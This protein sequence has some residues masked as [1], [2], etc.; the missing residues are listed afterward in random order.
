MIEFVE[1]PV[2]GQIDVGRMLNLVRHRVLLREP[3]PVVELVTTLLPLH[4]PM[5]QTAVQQPAQHVAMPDA[6]VHLPRRL[7]RPGRRHLLSLSEGVSTDDRLVRGRRGVNPLVLRIP[8]QLGVVP[9]SH[10]LDIDQ[11][12][13]LALLVPHLMTG[14]P[15]IPQ[16]RPDSAFRPGDSTAMPVPRPIVRARRSDAITREPLRD[17]VDSDTTEVLREDPP[18]YRRSDRVELEPVQANP[19]SGLRRIG[20][21]TSVTDAIPV[22]W[23]PSEEAAFD[24]GLRLHRGAHTHLD[25]GPLSLRHPTEHTHDQIVGFRRRVDRPTNLGHPHPDP[26]VLENRIREAVLIAVERALRLPDHDRVEPPV[27]IPETR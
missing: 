27:K 3:A 9:E 24:L 14:V 18:H 12:L 2:L 21:H 6:V 15:R 19:V 23:P 7:R 22:R 4:A 25:P 10:V 26:V 17:R 8:S 20:V 5:T 1:D 13:L 16:D 11:R